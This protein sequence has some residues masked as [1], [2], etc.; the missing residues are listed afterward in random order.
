MFSCRLS[1][2]GPRTTSAVAPIVRIASV[3]LVIAS[4]RPNLNNYFANEAKAKD[5]ANSVTGEYPLF[6]CSAGRLRDWGKRN[7]QMQLNLPATIQRPEL[8][9]SELPRG[10]VITS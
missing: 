8:S 2:T 4:P 1:E 5:F 9:E 3:R 10:Y 6:E 7:F